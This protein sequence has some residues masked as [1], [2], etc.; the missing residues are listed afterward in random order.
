[1]CEGYDKIADK[2]P[3]LCYKYI[4]LDTSRTISPI[5]VLKVEELKWYEIDDEQDL[6]YYA[7]ENIVQKLLREIVTKFKKQTFVQE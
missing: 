4:L 2:K 1:M 7:E 6:R 5:Y 3:K